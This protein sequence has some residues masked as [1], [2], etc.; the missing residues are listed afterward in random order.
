MYC[1]HNLKYLRVSISSAYISKDN[2]IVLSCFDEVCLVLAFMCL[3]NFISR[4]SFMHISTV[5][6]MITARSDPLKVTNYH[7]IQI[8]ADK[9]RAFASSESVL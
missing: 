9:Q 8:K 5:T 6:S 3:F 7:I 1:T 4:N 2:L